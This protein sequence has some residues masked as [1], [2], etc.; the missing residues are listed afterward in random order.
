MRTD[1]KQPFSLRKKNWLHILQ[2]R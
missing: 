1:N 2:Y